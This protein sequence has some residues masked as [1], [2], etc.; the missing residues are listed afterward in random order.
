MN[1][2]LLLLIAFFF[3]VAFTS[4]ANRYSVT[5]GLWSATTTWSATMVHQ[6]H[7]FQSLVMLFLLREDLML[8]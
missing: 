8:H 1:K 7:L 3:T 5:S 2:K 6:E 4:A